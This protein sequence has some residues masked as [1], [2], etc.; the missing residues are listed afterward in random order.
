MNLF[1]HQLGFSQTESRFP[2]KGTCLA[3]YS[4]AVN[5]ELPLGTVLL[6]HFPWCTAWEPQ[7]REL[8]AGYVEAKQTQGVLDY[9]DLLLYWAQMVSDPDV[10]RSYWVS[11]SIMCWWTSI[12]TPTGSSPASSWP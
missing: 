11:V 3:I 1:R 7:L 4:R 9:D 2:T 6:D 5:A 8:F 10:G 12:R